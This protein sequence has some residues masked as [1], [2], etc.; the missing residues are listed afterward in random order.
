[1]NIALHGIGLGGGIAIGQAFILDKDL[2]DVA[3]FTL[4][5]SE[6]ATEVLRFENALRSTRKELEYLRGNIPYDAPAELG[7]FLS[8]NI[9][10]LSDSQIAQAPVELIKRESCNAEWAIKLQADYLS[11]QFDEM[12]DEYLKERKT[13]VVQVLERIFRNLEGNKFDWNDEGKFERG[14][15][16]TRD[17]SPADLVHFKDSNFAGF[18]TDFG[19]R[20]S[21]TAIV[22]RNL[23]IPAVVGVANARQF[24]RED[25]IIIVDGIQGVVI[26]NPDKIVLNEYK[27]RKK[28][29][30]ESRQ[31]LRAIRKDET[32]TKDGV[33][34]EIFANI[35]VPDDVEDVKYNNAAGIGL[36]RSEFLFFSQDN[37]IAS[38]EEQ[39]EAY[40]KVVKVMKKLPITIRTADLGADKNPLW[41]SPHGEAENPALGLTGI[42]LSL[43]EHGFFRTQLRAILRASHY[44][45]IQIMFPMIS[46]AWELKQAVNQ[47]ELAKE[48]LRE[49]KIPFDNEI[50]VGSMIEIPAAALSLKGI[51]NYAD[52]I[53]IGTN[54]LI[55][56][57]L[58]I[59]RNDESV[60][61]LYDP[62]HPAVLQ[63]ISHV[64]R[65]AN[66]E[67]I[68]VSIC[69]E[70]AGNVKLTRL[71]LGMGLR[72]FSMYSANILNVKKIILNSDVTDIAN[73]VSKILRSESR[74]RIYE[75]VD[76]L[77]EDIELF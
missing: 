61:Y 48:E 66:K 36:F 30:L 32:V 59:D 31:K 15:L 38:E 23:D 9:M 43:A 68:P 18:I 71:L 77:N 70:M 57:L 26:I 58:A 74:E 29:W 69:G 35:E 34:V 11:H 55:Q 41:N 3:Q 33:K 40:L 53:S 16:V 50:K 45:E 6:V 72:K 28:E 37:H 8:L 20:T 60:S 44:G 1:M 42:R 21:H 76:Q 17:L 52:F 51:F 25:E 24:V 63:V 22:G 67:N 49:E 19:S 56:Y 10:M 7:A 14:I 54:D 64:I 5:D 2:E 73:K 65:T 12:E 47:L 13:D 75:L 62:L 39:F 4:E 27:R 46:S